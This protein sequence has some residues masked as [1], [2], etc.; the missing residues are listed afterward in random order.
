MTIEKKD[1]Y[2]K[3]V[4]DAITNACKSL[5]VPQERLEIEVITTGS[6]GIFGL[7]RKKAHIVASVKASEGDEEEKSVFASAIK[8]A[9]PGKKQKRERK[10]NPE[11]AKKSDSSET[12]KTNP[13][14]PSQSVG[15]T[16]DVRDEEGEE[17]PEIIEN[18][19]EEALE[20]IKRELQGLLEVLK[21]P[22]P[23]AVSAKGTMV[24]CNI[25]EQH[26]EILIGQDGKTLD[27]LQY[28]L[29]KIVTR[30]VEQKIRLTVDVG[31]YREKRLDELKTL[32]L[33]LA[34]K[35]KKDGKTEIIS[36]LSPSER[37]VI[38]MSLQ[39]DKDIRSRSV[40][41]GLFK[42][43]LI[44][45]P[46]KNAGKGSGKK[47]APRGRRSSGNRRKADKASS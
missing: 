26:K 15:A 39:H 34:E 43:I 14:Q 45:L 18:L 27:A 32:A 33:D 23:V 8:A 42:K 28:L 20:T 16:Q 37:R 10:A 21:C 30:K 29:R 44:Y 4:T 40:G 47:R 3:E 35:V 19:P 11:K 5:G 17:S 25:D 31:N 12:K 7:I 9:T 13:G 41:D 6:T 24:T 36:A 22:S 46:G 2:G 38:H 1:F